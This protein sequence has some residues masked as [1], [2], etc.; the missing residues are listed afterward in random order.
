MPPGET[1]PGGWDPSVYVQTAAQISQQGGLLF[2][3]PDVAAQPPH[4]QEILFRDVHGIPEP[5]G[6]MRLFEGKVTPQFYHLYPSL[7]ALVISLTGSV[8]AALWVNPLLNG[9]SI[10]LMYRFASCWTGH[11]RW[12]ALAA[13]LMLLLPLQI[14]QAKFS[15][16]EML[17]QVLILSG[18]GSLLQ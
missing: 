6:G 17:A 3:H 16:A 7:M 18:T 1:I 8:R 11:R 9:V 5:F 12:G 4:L 14:W 2:D 15:T 10:L 13:L